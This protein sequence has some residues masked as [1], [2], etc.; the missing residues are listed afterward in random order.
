MGEGEVPDVYGERH[1]LS[2]SPRRSA[3]LDINCISPNR[4][5]GQRAGDDS[6]GIGR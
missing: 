1:G 2:D 5:R 6:D 4:V 3:A